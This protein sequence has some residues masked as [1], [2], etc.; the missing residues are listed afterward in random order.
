MKC[1]RNNDQKT[2]LGMV[3]ILFVAWLPYIIGFAP[4]NINYDGMT[5]LLE[6]FGRLPHYD[7]HPVFITHFYGSIV[8]IGIL[9]KDYNLGVLL[10]VLFQAIL[11]TFTFS[12]VCMFVKKTCE[13]NTFIWI[14]LFYSVFPLWGGYVVC[15]IKDTFYMAVV[16]NFMIDFINGLNKVVRNEIIPKKDGLV[17]IVEMTLM[18]I[19]R[20]EAKL[21]LGFLGVVLLFTYKNYWK[22]ILL[23]GL[24]WGIVLVSYS[25]YIHTYLEIPKGEIAE[26]LSI[27]FQGTARYVKYHGGELTK[28][29]Y[30]AIDAILPVE[31]LADNYNPILSDKIKGRMKSGCTKKQYIQYALTWTKMG[32]KHPE[33]YLQAYWENYSGYLNPFYIKSSVP[34]GIDF[35]DQVPK[36]MELPISYYSQESEL[37]MFLCNYVAVIKKIPVLNWLLG[38]GFYV[39]GIIL[40]WIYCVQTKKN[41]V[42]LIYPTLTIGIC[43]MSAANG[44]LRYVLTVAS[45]LPLLICYYTSDLRKEII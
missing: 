28:A 38:A 9:I 29:E 7:H 5:Q 39:W 33:V 37:R 40:L 15:V 10:I 35:G 42:P 22:N 20:H 4:G 18:S 31:E 23:L 11:C 34:L 19:S 8:K 12:R 27:P 30:E 45:T 44:Y 25:W 36:E 41:Y 16:T 21:C 6:Y 26:A 43:F 24:I 13:N 1:L 32:M 3:C 14:L 17:L 2:Y